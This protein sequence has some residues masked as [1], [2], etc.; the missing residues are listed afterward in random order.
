VWSAEGTTHR[1]A[2]EGQ[3]TKRKERVSIMECGY[4]VE[5]HT[6]GREHEKGAGSFFSDFS[7]CFIVFHNALR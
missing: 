5:M 7:W 1:D 6:D 3:H 4:R 2:H